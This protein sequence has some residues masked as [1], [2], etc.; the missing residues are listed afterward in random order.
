MKRRA[1]LSGVALGL[2]AGPLCA[3]APQA[4]ILRR[5]GILSSGASS[6]VE[7]FRQGLRDLGWIEGQSVVIEARYAGEHLD[8][9]PELAAE[10][11][12]RRVEVIL[13]TSSTFVR[14]AKQATATIP[15]VFSAHN[16]P[17]GTGDVASLARPGGTITGVTQMA[18]DLTAKQLQIL[19]EVVP[20][21]MHIAVLWN[22]TTPS[23]VPS[24]S[25]VKAA[26]QVLGVR[27]Q[28]L[29][30]ASLSEFERAFAT[31]ARE[32]AA[33]ALILTSP[34]SYSARGSIAALELNQRLPTMLG[35]R[36]Y[37]EAGGLISYAPSLAAL[38]RSAAA[39]VDKI[40]RGAKPA[41]LPVEQPTRFQ[42][43][44][45]LRTAKLLG[46][47][48]PPSVLLRADEVIQ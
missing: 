44:L 10:L 24:L 29:Q 15:I 45:N 42:L 5:I 14:A 40:L 47:K 48:I 20:N 37:V 25:E 31:A 26:A 46:L 11:V 4:G 13:A 3:Q 18:T 6:N 39:Y 41:D 16:D 23:H 43:V 2:V 8:R 36:E 1:F 32:G 17:V 9:L 21:A 12:G 33:A 7:A 34:A 38:G 30:A 28:I 27:L 22:P 35:Y 19:R